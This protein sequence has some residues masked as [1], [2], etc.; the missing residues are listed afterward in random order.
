MQALASAV[1]ASTVFFTTDPLSL[2]MSRRTAPCSTAL[3]MIRLRCAC[4]VATNATRV[5]AANSVDVT[6]S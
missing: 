6:T 1:T 3:W 5:T 2:V 4:G